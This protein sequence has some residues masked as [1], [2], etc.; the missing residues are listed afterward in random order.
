MI[1]RRIITQDFPLLCN[2]PPACLE[3]V[4]HAVVETANEAL[5]PLLVALSKYY[6]PSQLDGLFLAD[7]S[8]SALP[9]NV[10]LHYLAM[11]PAGLRMLQIRS[12]VFG[13]E[14]LR[15]VS[16]G[17]A[18][19]T[20][21]ILHMGDNALTNATV[22]H[23]RRFASLRELRFSKPLHHLK[24]AF[25]G[26]LC[27]LKL[28]VLSF[29]SVK[30]PLAVLFVRLLKEIPTLRRI[31]FLSPR[32]FADEIQGNLRDQ[33]LE[34]PNRHNIE[35]IFFPF[36]TPIFATP[37]DA[38]TYHELF[39]NLTGAH[40]TPLEPSPFNTPSCLRRISSVFLRGEITQDWID[41]AA[42]SWPKLSSLHAIGNGKVDMTP[43]VGL[44]E[45]TTQ[46]D[47]V[48]KFP[49]SLRHLSITSDGVQDTGT[50]FSFAAAISATATQL[51]CL[52]FRVG[53]LWPGHILASLPFLTKLEHIRLEECSPM[54]ISHKALQELPA[55]PQLPP[56]FL[57]SLRKY[58]CQYFVVDLPKRMPSLHHLTLDLDRMDKSWSPLDLQKLSKLAT[59]KISAPDFS[60]DTFASIKCLRGLTELQIDRVS[61][62]GW[63][64]L[65]EL[66]DA[67]PIARALVVRRSTI[68]PA[69]QPSCKHL[70]L[71][72]IALVE[73]TGTRGV[74]LHFLGSSLP[75]LREIMVAT[76]M[77]TCVVEVNSCPMLEYFT[78]TGPSQSI[79]S[80][81]ITV[82]SCSLL[83]VIRLRSLKLADLQVLKVPS[84]QE[85]AGSYLE[86][87]KDPIFEIT[88]RANAP[89]F[90]CSGVRGE[91]AEQMRRTIESAFA[92]AS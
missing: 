83:R 13:D 57:P 85:F 72:S 11:L 46:L 26:A 17:K 77:S 30:I 49:A 6:S 71:T 53:F 22:E 66:L 81:H 60:V 56:G 15:V 74:E 48:S 89:R 78:V 50:Y 73:F 82:N 7:P 10:A 41:A 70:H 80:S 79:D 59:L 44:V 67:V 33:I 58:D 35:D 88:S 54:E 14:E 24:S 76:F 61:T 2:L 21:E 28:E 12:F 27:S 1:H 42:L 51:E 36:S 91:A 65:E 62:E 40:A 92:H 32:M 5:L 52:S 69:L 63:K 18:A 39:P 20:L 86:F 87:S 31:G 55:A 19:E 23:W 64:T 25:L 47:C 29:D 68:N 16:S 34:C 43:L 38:F 4:L 45:L 3:L 37:E 84:W 8:L 90:D 9:R 75:C